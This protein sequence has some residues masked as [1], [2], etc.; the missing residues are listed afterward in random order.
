MLQLEEPALHLQVPQE[1]PVPEPILQAAAGHHFTL[2]LA[3]SGN[4]WACGN[5]AR[6]QLGLGSKLGPEVREPRRVKAL[7]GGSDRHT[8]CCKV[9]GSR[10]RR[11][12][13]GQAAARHLHLW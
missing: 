9:Q 8:L 1:V 12:H 10:C 2:L 6:G 11:A 7:E 4:L 13:A 3:Q 5:N